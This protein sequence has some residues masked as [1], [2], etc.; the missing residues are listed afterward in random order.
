MFCVGITRFSYYKKDGFQAKP[1]GVNIPAMS[2]EVPK[3]NPQFHSNKGQ[4]IC[5]KNQK[6]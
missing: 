1:Y 2:L 5:G 6:A 3:E 4:K